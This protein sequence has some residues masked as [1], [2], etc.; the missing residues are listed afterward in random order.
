[1]VIGVIPA[2]LHSKR[3]PN[4]ILAPINDKPM[5]IHVYD[6]A[7]EADKLDVV[8]TVSYTNLRAHET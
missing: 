2:R 7:K 3:F 1:M 4:K 6:R 5:V 8:I